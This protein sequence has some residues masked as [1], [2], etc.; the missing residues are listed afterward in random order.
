MYKIPTTLYLLIFTLFNLIAQSNLSNLEY[1]I[2]DQKESTITSTDFFTKSNDKIYSAYYTLKKDK[3]TF[4]V[5]EFDSDYKLLK[6]EQLAISDNRGRVITTKSDEN[7]VYIVIEQIKSKTRD[8]SLITVDAKS[9]KVVK[10]EILFSSTENKGIYFPFIGVKK[11]SQTT[12]ILNKLNNGKIQKDE[13]KVEC[14]VLDKQNHKIWAKTIILPYKKSTQSSIKEFAVGDNGE[15]LISVKGKKESYLHYYDS[16]GELIAKKDVTSIINDSGTYGLKNYQTKIKSDGTILLAGLVNNYPKNNEI[17]YYL[18]DKD[19]L[20]ITSDKAFEIPIDKLL[21]NFTEKEQLKEKKRIE[22]GKDVVVDNFVKVTDVILDN[23]D[24]YII[25]EVRYNGVR[26]FSAYREL[27]VYKINVK[28]ELV[29]T[30]V[31]S[32]NQEGQ[33][34]PNYDSNGGVSYGNYQGDEFSYSLL[35]NE[36]NLYFIFN[37]VNSNLKTINGK[38]NRYRINDNKSCISICQLSEEGNLSKQNIGLEHIVVKSYNYYLFNS[39]DKV[40]DK[41]TILLRLDRVMTKEDKFLLLSFQ[42]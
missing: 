35:I 14:L 36:N 42:K 37:D 24:L 40:L 31:I 23:D 27:I 33:S 5:Q 21:Y 32:K 1:N 16:K 29:W 19:D 34:A 20:S 11:S 4:G 13:I 18:F 2:V 10:E 15:I 8:F 6:E 9:L 25:G 41:N 3:S 28:N 30:K 12:L 22:K 38:V 26:G 17:V 39:S 7:N